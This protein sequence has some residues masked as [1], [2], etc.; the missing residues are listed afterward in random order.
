VRHAPDE[1][2]RSCGARFDAHKKARNGGYDCPPR[3]DGKVP[4]VVGSEIIG[5]DYDNHCAISAPKI[6]WVDP[7]ATPTDAGER[8][9]P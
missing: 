1:P 5:M 2:C 3:E 7:S 8:G 6:E 9:T 4:V